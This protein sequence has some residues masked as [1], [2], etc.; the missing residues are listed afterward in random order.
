[1]DHFTVLIRSHN[2]L[3]GVLTG[4][5]TQAAAFQLV[6][7]ITVINMEGKV[8]WKNVV[9]VRLFPSISHPVALSLLFYH[10]LTQSDSN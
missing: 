4:R 5:V 10:H 3:I 9:C 8:G 2:A 7:L 6:T 1:M